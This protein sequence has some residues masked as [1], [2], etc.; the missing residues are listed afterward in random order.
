MCPSNSSV[1]RPSLPSTGSARGAFPCF[2]GT[3]ESSD[4]RYPFR[5]APFSSPDRTTRVPVASLP[6]PAGTPAKSLEGCCP[7]P[8]LTGSLFQVE[9]IGPP[10][11]LGNPKVCMPCS[12]TPAGWTMPGL[13][14]MSMQPSAVLKASAPAMRSFRGSITRPTHALSTLRSVGCPR[15]TQ[16]SLPAGGQPLPGGIDYPTGFLRT[17]SR[18]LPLPSLPSAQASPGAPRP[19]PDSWFLRLGLNLR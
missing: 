11:F 19:D 2:I 15:T 14:G 7:V 16:D 6:S 17:I 5:Q 1:N 9:G 3:T 13:Y 12:S 4:S 10:R 18:R 8:P